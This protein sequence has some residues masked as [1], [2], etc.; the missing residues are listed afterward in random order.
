MT[1]ST[2]HGGDGVWAA[3]EDEKRRDRLLRR[4]STVAWTVTFVL[5]L[6]LAVLIGVQ[7]SQMMRAVSAGAAPWTAPVWSAMPLIVVLGVLSVLIATL[8]TIGIFLRLRTASLA[9]IQMRLASL[10]AMLASRPD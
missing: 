10:E 2:E 4:V 6:V 9:E 8:S 5:V 7:V 1:D 3:I